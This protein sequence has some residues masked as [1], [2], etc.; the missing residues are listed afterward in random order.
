MSDGYG[1]ATGYRLLIVSVPGRQYRPEHVVGMPADEFGPGYTPLF[2]SDSLIPE[3]LR[4]L[5][6]EPPVPLETAP[7]VSRETLTVLQARGA[8]HVAIDPRPDNPRR[9]IP[10]DDFYAGLEPD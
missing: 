7:L 5:T 2:T 9:L 4:F 1:P 3:W 10:I 8:T 6:H